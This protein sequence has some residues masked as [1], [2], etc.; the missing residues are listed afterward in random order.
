[1]SKSIVREIDLE[2]V[3]RFL[4]KLLRKEGI[5]NILS[6]MSLTMTVAKEF[7]ITEVEAREAMKQWVRS[8]LSDN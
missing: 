8:D 1:M 4:N 7:N 5:L 6:V 3:S 2:A